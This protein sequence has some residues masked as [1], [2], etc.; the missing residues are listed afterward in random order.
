MTRCPQQAY[1]ST[2]TRFASPAPTDSDTVTVMSQPPQQPITQHVVPA[3]HAV[4]QHPGSAQ[5]PA[6]QYVMITQPSITQQLSEQLR[7]R[8]LTE[9][10]EPPLIEE[11]G[12]PLLP[13]EILAESTIE[14]HNRAALRIY[15]W[16]AAIGAFFWVLFICMVLSVGN[17]VLMMVGLLFAMIGGADTLVASAALLG[18]AG[19]GL[20]LSLAMIPLGVFWAGRIR[21]REL[22]SEAAFQRAIAHRIA[23]AF[24]APMACACLILAALFVTSPLRELPTY[25]YASSWFILPNLFLPGLTTLVMFWAV[26]GALRAANPFK[27]PIPAQLLTAASQ[28]PTSAE[29]A[30]LL[31]IVHAQDRR[32]LPPNVPRLNARV[33]AR[34]TLQ[35]AKTA[36]PVLF[37][38]A[39]GVTMIVQLISL[40]GP[41]TAQSNPSIPVIDIVGAP[42][43]WWVLPA[44][45][46]VSLAWLACAGPIPAVLMALLRPK[47]GQVQDLRTYTT[48]A[49]RYRVNR[50]EYRVV[51]L[52]NLLIQLVTALTAIGFALIAVGGGGDPGSIMMAVILFWIT[53]LP[54]NA[55]FTQAI[56]GRNLR[57]I[58]YGPA[59]R[60]MRRRTPI[61]AVTLLGTTRS[62]YA[63]QPDVRAAV[64]D[65]EAKAAAQPAP[66]SN[67]PASQAPAPTGQPA[68]SNSGHAPAGAT[69]NGAEA[70]VPS[71]VAAAAAEQPVVALPDFGGQG[72]LYTEFEVSEP[73]TRDDYAIPE[74]LDSLAP[75]T[76]KRRWFRRKR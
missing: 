41:S 37:M 19:A 10:P 76:T 35:V 73:A 58:V 71:G 54:F 15:P 3:Q 55:L 4:V 63:N 31:G 56:M 34:S 38:A 40:S 18:A 29:A 26:R 68:H 43:Q 75:E 14:L 70:A 30:R 16:A 72:D 45:I 36:V 20:I 51:V 67:P 13:S 57:Q 27:L 21:P 28:A 5:Q 1:L 65:A 33:L 7:A 50:W 11:A 64:R 59:G 23:L 47:P 52:S 42:L 39:P 66:A 9:L 69:P 25:W 74:D 32:H 61:A 48:P 62:A 46:G 2:I 6:M 44:V 8:P 53:L 12:E 24:S 49:E 17:P 22:L 60:Y